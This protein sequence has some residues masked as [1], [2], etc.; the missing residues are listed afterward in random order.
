MYQQ[1]RDFFPLI[2]TILCAYSVTPPSPCSFLI[3]FTKN[4]TIKYHYC[5]HYA[6]EEEAQDGREIC[7]HF[8]RFPNHSDWLSPYILALTWGR[9]SW[10]ASDRQMGLEEKLQLIHLIP[11]PEKQISGAGCSTVAGRMLRCG[12][13][14]EQGEKSWLQSLRQSIVRDYG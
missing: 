7:P 1:K 8:P 10:R 3:Y 5:P 11:S 4:P 13:S 9:A 14:L 12:V 2:K 6:E